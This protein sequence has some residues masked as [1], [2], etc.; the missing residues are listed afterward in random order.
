MTAAETIVTDPAVTGAAGAPQG[1]AA[2]GYR[3]RSIGS[4]AGIGGSRERAR[5]NL[6]AARAP[7]GATVQGLLRRRA[8]LPAG[9]LDQ[10]CSGILTERP[11]RST[12]LHPGRRT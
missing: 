10:L 11:A 7:V 9:H 2:D 12:C 8:D 6:L 3:L 4:G 5:V 1:A